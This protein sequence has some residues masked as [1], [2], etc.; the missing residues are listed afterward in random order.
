[1]SSE[2]LAILP[3]EP[4]KNVATYHVPALEV[5]ISTLLCFVSLIQY[6]SSSWASNHF[7]FDIHFFQVTI[8]FDVF[9]ITSGQKLVIT[10]VDGTITRLL[11]LNLSFVGL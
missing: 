11:S 8:H 7:D 3:L 1:M 9:L 6:I 10:D 5:T 4:G 2:E